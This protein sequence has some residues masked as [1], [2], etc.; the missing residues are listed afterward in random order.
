MM[1]KPTHYVVHYAG[2][3]EYFARRSTARLFRAGLALRG[4]P[5]TIEAR[6]F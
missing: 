2:R 5:S 4:I 3:R 6:G 1:A